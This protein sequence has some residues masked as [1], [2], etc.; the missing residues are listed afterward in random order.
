MMFGS[1]IVNLLGRRGLI[2]IER[3]MGMILVAIAI[4]MFLT[5]ADTYFVRG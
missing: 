1:R 5:G 2:A 3:L 4:Q